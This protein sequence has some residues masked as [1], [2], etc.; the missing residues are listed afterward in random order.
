[1][2]YSYVHIYILYIFYF[3][4]VNYIDLLAAEATLAVYSIIATAYVRRY[5]CVSV[6][7][8]CTGLF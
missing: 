5:V 6:A 4:T 7:F 3:T 8:I 2:L 1:M